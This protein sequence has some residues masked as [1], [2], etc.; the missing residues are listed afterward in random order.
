MKIIYK[1]FKI[2][3]LRVKIFILKLRKIIEKEYLFFL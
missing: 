3:S 2:L 1:I